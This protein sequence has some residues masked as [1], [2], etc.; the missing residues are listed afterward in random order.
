M[1]PANV[2]HHTTP[3]TPENVL[4]PDVS[5]NPERLQALC[6]DCHTEVHKRLGVGAMG[7]ARHEECRVCFDSEGNVISR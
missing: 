4:D 1:K 5:L 7:S 3:L 2:V 6:H